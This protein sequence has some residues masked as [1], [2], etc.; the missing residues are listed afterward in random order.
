MRVLVMY[1]ACRVPGSTLLCRSLA[2]VLLLRML[3]AGRPPSKR[4][5]AGTQVYRRQL[6]GRL[7]LGR[8]LLVR[9]LL[10]RLLLVRRLLVVYKNHCRH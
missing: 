8:L 3:L 10:T 4:P 2:A 9:L 7:L 1:V 6:L 5:S